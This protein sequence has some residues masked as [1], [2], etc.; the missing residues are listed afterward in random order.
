MLFRSDSLRPL[1]SDPQQLSNFVTQTP[2]LAERA[3]EEDW[4][5]F[6]QEFLEEVRQVPSQ[7]IP[8]ANE[9]RIAADAIQAIG[10]APPRKPPTR[11]KGNEA[12]A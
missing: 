12:V 8:G 9:A 10:A 7:D 4:P 1:L 2:A 11:K 6:Q 3:R 5:G